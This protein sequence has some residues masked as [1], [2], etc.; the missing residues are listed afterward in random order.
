VWSRSSIRWAAAPDGSRRVVT[1]DGLPPAGNPLKSSQRKEKLKGRPIVKPIEIVGVDDDRTRIP[2]TIPVKG[3]KPL[4]ISLPRFDYLD[5][6]TFD[7]LTV[8]LAELNTNTDLPERKRGRL[9]ALAMLKHVVTE[10]QFAVLETLA[11][12]M[13]DQVLE[14]W[15][16]H[17]LVS[18]G[19]S[20]ASENSSTENTGAP[21]KPTSSTVGGGEPTSGTG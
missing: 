19:E 2:F 21:S 7:A 10:H 18:L 14:G 6:D 1:W 4:Q 13:L 3:R 11:T 8:D 20:P 5:E 12:G 16:T 17:S 9:I 15:R